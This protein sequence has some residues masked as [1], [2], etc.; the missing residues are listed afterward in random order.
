[1]AGPRLDTQ[2]REPLL[3][4]RD[5][6]PVADANR[7]P[8]NKTGGSYLRVLII[9]Y[10]LITLGQLHAGIFNTALKQLVEG[11][12]CRQ[13]HDDVLDPTRDP[14]CKGERTQA[15]LSLIFSLESTFEMVPSLLLSIPYGIMADIYGRRFVAFLS[16]LGCLVYPVADAFVCK[17]CP[18]DGKVK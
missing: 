3:A 7:Q 15:E 5:G 13:Y 10:T 9:G 4:P 11:L 17:F 8:A 18:C 2:E 14:R 1:M 16:I 12:L 6:A